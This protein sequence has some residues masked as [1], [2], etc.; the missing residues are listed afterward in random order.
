MTTGMVGMRSLVLGAAVVGAFTCEPGA[1]HTRTG[2]ETASDGDA[3]LREAELLREGVTLIRK[4][5][6]R[7]D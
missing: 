4:D 1:A 6:N 7:A 2:G 5:Q 3:V